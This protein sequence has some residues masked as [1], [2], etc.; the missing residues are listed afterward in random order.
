M[1]SILVSSYNR[2]KL[3]RRTLYWLSNFPPS[4]P[5]ELIIADDGSTDDILGEVRKFNFKGKFIEVDTTEFTKQTGVEKFWNCP[6]LTANIAF[7]H[8]S[9]DLIV[10][11]GNEIIPFFYAIDNMIEEMAQRSANLVFSETYDI[12]PQIINTLDENGNNLSKLV[13]HCKQYPLANHK[14]CNNVT[15]YL[16]LCTRELWEEIGGYDERYLA[17][18]GKEDSDW[19]RRASAT[20][21]FK[22]H[23]GKACSFHQYHGGVNHFYRPL[24]SVISEERLAQGVQI[25]RDRYLAWD[26]KVQNSQPWTPGSIGVKKVHKL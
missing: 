26:G 12:P 20:Q 7:A 11:M 23:R 9:H 22:L 17:G 5:F 3:F 15:N 19:Y 16:S 24:P 4:Y 8:A 14:V 10:Q 6:A 25:N 21:Y 1:I 2:I 13:E 18:I